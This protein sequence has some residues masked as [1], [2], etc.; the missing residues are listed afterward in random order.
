MSD[1]WLQYLWIKS[2]AIGALSPRPPATVSG[3]HSNEYQLRVKI[4]PRV[5]CINLECNHTKIAVIYIPYSLVVRI[6]GFHP[7]DPGSIPGVGKHFAN[8]LFEEVNS[9]RFIAL[10]S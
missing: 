10:I 9:E 8:D 6:S 5:L 4:V 2:K 3:V 1:R 7:E